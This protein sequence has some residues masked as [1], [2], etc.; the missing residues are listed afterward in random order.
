MVWLASSPN[1]FSLVSRPFLAVGRLACL[2]TV[3]F[4]QVGEYRETLFDKPFYF[5]HLFPGGVYER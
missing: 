3:H 4:T 2:N 1:S 5:C